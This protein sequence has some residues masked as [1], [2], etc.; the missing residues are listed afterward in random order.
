MKRILLTGLL[1]LMATA[2]VLAED[3][4][5][6]KDVDDGSYTI[7][8]LKKDMIRVK[9]ENCYLVMLSQWESVVNLEDTTLSQDKKDYAK[10]IRSIIEKALIGEASQDVS[11]EPKK[12]IKFLYQLTMKP[13]TTDTNYGIP[14]VTFELMYTVVKKLVYECNVEEDKLREAYKT[15]YGVEIGF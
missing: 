2:V 15:L 1:L 6:A 4:K 13:N 11:D 3:K 7:I 12:S 8:Q 5:Q 9:I 10:K 14:L